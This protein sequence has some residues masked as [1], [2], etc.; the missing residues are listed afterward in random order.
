MKLKFIEEDHRIH[1]SDESG[2]LLA[3][4][5]FPLVSSDVVNIDRTFVDESLR[6]QGVADQ[7]MRL[8]VE[9]MQQR[10]LKA[11]LTCSYAKRWFSS[12]PECIELL[13]D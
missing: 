12:H 8:V 11:V 3:E 10:R 7:L 13:H 6:G 1:A 5:T 9:H 4:I 2:K